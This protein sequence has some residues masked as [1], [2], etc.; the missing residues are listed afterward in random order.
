MSGRARSHSFST[1]A[2][3]GAPRP[4]SSSV[5]TRPP[6]VL[7]PPAVALPAAASRTDRHRIVA[8][9]FLTHHG[10]DINLAGRGGRARSMSIRRLTDAELVEAANPLHPK[11]HSLTAPERAMATRETQHRA[12]A[13]AIG[14][15]IHSPPGG[16]HHSH[17]PAHPPHVHGSSAV[18]A[19][20]AAMI[21]MG[22]FGQSFV[23]EAFRGDPVAGVPAIVPSP[24]K[25]M[26]VA[27]STAAAPAS[28]GVGISG[29]SNVAGEVQTIHGRLTASLA[30]DSAPAGYPGAPAMG[31]L[32][33]ADPSPG[34]RQVTGVVG[35]DAIDEVPAIP[36]RAAVVGGLPVRDFVRGTPFT[37]A[38]AAVA[39]VQQRMACAALNAGFAA[40]VLPG[41]GGARVDPRAAAVAATPLT[42]EL[43]TQGQM[44][45]E[46]ILNPTGAPAAGAGLPP[47]VLGAGAGAAPPVVLNSGLADPMADSY[48]TI[49]RSHPSTVAAATAEA[50]ALAPQPGTRPRSQSLSAMTESCRNCL[51]GVHQ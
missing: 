7:P 11:G 17:G 1:P 12:E 3:G 34:I 38:V 42:P 23:D 8:D 20:D 14:G 27:R 22:R 48:T 18:L 45:Y 33:A 29:S 31:V 26:G 15:D 24:V 10:Q 6:V 46:A 25:Q 36:Y 41:A 49:A 5:G 30:A 51:T 2:S 37:P 50:A 35:S 43:G 28:Y 40:N 39:A 16:A 32:S 19:P 47:P 4:R 44:L 13:L 21:R 9:T